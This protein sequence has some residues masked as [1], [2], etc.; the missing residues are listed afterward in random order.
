MSLHIHNPHSHVGAPAP[1]ITVIPPAIP[2]APSIHFDDLYDYLDGLEARLQS[3][4]TELDAEQ[5]E[6]LNSLA[7]QLGLQ[8]AATTSL[9]S[10]LIDIELSAEIRDK[11]FV[12]VFSKLMQPVPAPATLP[13]PAPVHTIE[14]FY[15]TDDTTVEIIERLITIVE[16]LASQVKTLTAIVATTETSIWTKIGRFLGLI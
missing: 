2:A 8:L 10:H 15:Q 6:H 16:D 11:D 1:G 12:Q 13:A 3:R 5:R 9:A 4:Q 14:R 7:K